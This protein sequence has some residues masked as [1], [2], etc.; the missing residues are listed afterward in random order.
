MRRHNHTRSLLLAVAASLFM[1]AGTAV[2]QDNAELEDLRRSYLEIKADYEKFRDIRD[3]PERYDLKLSLYAAEQLDKLF[4]ALKQHEQMIRQAGGKIPSLVTIKVKPTSEVTATDKATGT[5]VSRGV[6]LVKTPCDDYPEFEKPETS[7]YV[8][9][10]SAKQSGAKRVLAGALKAA[11]T[12]LV[13]H[14]TTCENEWTSQTALD[15]DGRMH[16]LIGQL[17][18]LERRYAMAFASPRYTDEENSKLAQ[19]YK[20]SPALKRKARNEQMLF[21]KYMKLQELADKEVPKYKYASDTAT[22]LR[23]LDI[24]YRTKMALD[25]WWLVANQ[26]TDLRGPQLELLKTVNASRLERGLGE[27]KH[28]HPDAVI[29]FHKKKDYLG[30]KSPL[31]VKLLGPAGMDILKKEYDRRYKASA[32][33]Q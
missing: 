5:K 33:Q 6:K 10:P 11:E 1:W 14:L 27:I 8:F 31:L 16:K 29:K 18:E 2:S 15:W 17:L 23:L 7:A 22:R 3:N 4:R 13:E 21:A 28:F 32:R 30:T 9:P 26:I 25:A 19:A 12:T 24:L 20:D